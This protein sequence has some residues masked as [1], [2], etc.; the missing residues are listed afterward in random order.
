[1]ARAMHGTIPVVAGSALTAPIAY[2]WKTQINTNAKVPA[3]AHELPELEYN[4]L[5]G[6]AGAAE[7][8]RFSAVF[9]DDCDLHPRVKSRI[10]LTE[11]IVAKAARHSFR[12]QTR[13]ET[14]VE[15][16]V[17]L[18]LLGDLVS[19]YMAVLGGRDPSPVPVLEAHRRML[20]EQ[21]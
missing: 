2:R 9:L 12:V 10:A 18:V 11:R 15:R 13:G 16:V 5:A 1:M 7:V 14:T 4:E 8:G 19:L 3:F 17:S 21:E 6:W 20:A